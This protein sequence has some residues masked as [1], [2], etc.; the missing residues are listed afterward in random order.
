MVT[1]IFLSSIHFGYDINGRPYIHLNDYPPSNSR[2]DNVW[3]ECSL[4]SALGITIHVMV[5]GAGGAFQDLFSNYEIFYPMLVDLIKSHDFIKGINLDIEEEVNIKDVEKLIADLVA[6]FG[7]DFIIS[8]A[9]LSYALVS[10]TA[11]MGGFVVKDLMNGPVGKYID[12][13]N[14][15]FYGDFNESTYDQVIKNGYKPEQVVIGMLSDEFD[16]N[17]IHE[18]C[19][20]VTGIKNKYPKFAGVFTWEYFNAPP[21]KNNPADWAKY[22]YNSINHN[23]LS[24]LEKI[25]HD[26][27]M[28]SREVNSCFRKKHR[29]YSSSGYEK[30]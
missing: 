17:S 4:A 29:C 3:H 1:D 24:L 27:Y 13:L 2:F 11:G 5:G 12:F 30:I 18:L 9:P 19:K 10:D 6:D 28:F 22:L 15:Q 7:E 23:S 21:N 25:K 14:G 16:I 8:L 26:C 20:I